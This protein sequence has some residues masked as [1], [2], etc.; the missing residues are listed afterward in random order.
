M[1]VDAQQNTGMMYK[2]G[3]GLKNED[4][5]SAFMWFYAAH[6][7]GNNKAEIYMDNLMVEYKLS[8]NQM[9]RARELAEAYIKHDKDHKLY[10]ADPE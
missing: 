4:F 1:H 10:S 9:K 5:I 2:N 8:P 6:E 3:Y 7:Q